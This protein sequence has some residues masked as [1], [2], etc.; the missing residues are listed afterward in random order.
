MENAAQIPAAYAGKDIDHRHHVVVGID[1]GADFSLHCGDIGQNL[2][3]GFAGPACVQRNGVQCGDRIHG[4]FRNPDVDQIL[5]AAY[6]VQ[7]VIG[8]GLA[9]AGKIQQYRARHVTLGQSDLGC[10]G[11]VDV[12]VQFGLIGRLLDPDIHG[13]RDIADGIGKL[14]CDLSRFFTVPAHDLNIDRGRETEVDGLID[15]IG[16]QKIKRRSGKVSSQAGAQ[17]ANITIRG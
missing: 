16:R 17:P 4:V 5:N 13:A 3:A 11:A 7:P 1:G 15:D 8:L 10:L 14:C 6:R 9:A 12:K 2:G